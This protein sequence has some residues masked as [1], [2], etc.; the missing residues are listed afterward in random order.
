[1]IETGSSS[2]IYH[3]SFPESG[4]KELPLET[5]ATAGLVSSCNPPAC[6]TGS[7]AG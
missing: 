3:P 5:K 4:S 2:W 7:R 1:M 6:A